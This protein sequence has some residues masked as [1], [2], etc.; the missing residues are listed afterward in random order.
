MGNE[1]ATTSAFP[2]ETWERG[3]HWAA[4]FQLA[5]FRFSALRV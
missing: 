2:S 1:I 4:G 5:R 3:N